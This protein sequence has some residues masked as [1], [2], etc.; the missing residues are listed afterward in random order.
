[1]GIVMHY[2]GAMLKICIFVFLVQFIY[3]CIS[4][5]SIMI[6]IKSLKNSSIRVIFICYIA[7][8]ITQLLVPP[9]DYY[10]QQ[11]YLT[12]DLSIPEIGRYKPNFIPFR[13]IINEITG[14]GIDVNPEDLTGV[15]TL[16]LL[17]NVLLMVPFGILTPFVNEKMRDFKKFIFTSVIIFV[18]VEILQYFLGRIMDIDDVIL[19]TCGAV[20]G[21]YL[22]NFISS[23]QIVNHDHKKNI[24]Q[25]INNTVKS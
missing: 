23:H 17:G 1:M 6:G 9:Y 21:Y 22:F 5:R 14:K 25:S 4:H 16:N 13:S 19:N 2:I 8:L 10:I 7:G 20:L 11:G 12:F 24:G 3:H 18:M 15:K